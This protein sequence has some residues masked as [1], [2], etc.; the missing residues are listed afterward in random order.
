M[1]IILFSDL[2]FRAS[3]NFHLPEIKIH[4]SKTDLPTI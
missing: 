3:D 1:D 2:S 4:L